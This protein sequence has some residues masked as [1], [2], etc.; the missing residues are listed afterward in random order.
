[1]TRYPST[2]GSDGFDSAQSGYRFLPS[3]NSNGESPLG[4]VPA[5][6]AVLRFAP[7]ATYVLLRA[8][9]AATAPR[10]K[11]Q[12]TV[13]NCRH[14]EYGVCEKQLRP[15]SR[16]TVCCLAGG[17]RSGAIPSLWSEQRF[18]SNA[19]GRGRGFKPSAW[20]WSSAC[21]HQLPDGG[22]LHP[23]PRLIAVV[24]IEPVTAVARGTSIAWR[25]TSC[26]ASTT[27][28][29]LPWGKVKVSVLWLHRSPDYA[30]AW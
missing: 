13:A 15:Q 18:R 25:P 9:R 14:A 27:N 2:R 5:N 22:H 7:F 12:Q 1:M 28:A 17:G 16:R 8:A 30:V 11:G 19:N 24:E 23:S 4:R 10:H 26:L 3:A 29:E 21:R 6:C 20:T